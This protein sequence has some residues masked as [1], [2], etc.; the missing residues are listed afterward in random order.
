MKESIDSLERVREYYRLTKPGIIRGNVM[1]AV[2]GYL[3]AAQGAIDM[4]LLLAVA[5]GVICIIAAGCVFN[6]YIDRD[7]DAKMTRTKN[8]ALVTGAIK[9][10]PALIFASVLGLVGLT[11][12]LVF[13]NGIAALIGLLAF[14]SYVVVYGYAK[15]KSVHGTLVGSLPGAL[16]LVAGYTAV[17]SRFDLTALLLLLIMAVWQLP[18]FYAIAIYRINDYR[19]AKLPILSIKNGIHSTKRHIV[20][21]IVLFGATSACLTIFSYAGYVYL[22][23]MG[24]MSVAWLW[25]ALK[26]FNTTNV[27]AWA[28]SVFG[29]S[30]IV[31][32]V[33]SGLISINNFLP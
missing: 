24:F 29:F 22:V 3:F 18:H 32:L 20:A 6:N 27:D 14:I 2:A 4:G 1:T 7:I 15:R 30:L 9:A 12:L 5:T 33:F 25:I 28:K 13:T 16:S 26:G 10:Q 21:Y 11:I 19:A 31:L 8:R 17:V 23:T